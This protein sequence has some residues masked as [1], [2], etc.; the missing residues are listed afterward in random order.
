M[1]DERVGEEV[2]AWIR[3]KQGAKLTEF[4]LKEFCQGNISHFKIPK[5]VKFIDSFPINANNKVLKNKIK[6]M[7][8]EEIKLNK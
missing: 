1:P 5:Y 3:L 4:E 7:A 2:A 6:E 8:I